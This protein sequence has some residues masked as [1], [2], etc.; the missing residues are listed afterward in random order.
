MMV[1]SS[2][3]NESMRILTNLKRNKN[4]ML[5]Q[6]RNDTKAPQYTDK[7]KTRFPLN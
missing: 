7:E 4:I 3:Y 6:K 1:P 2:I 5:L